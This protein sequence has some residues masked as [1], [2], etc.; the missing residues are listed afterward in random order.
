M[1]RL[2]SKRPRLRLDPEGYDQLRK[3]DL[4][5]SGATF[6]GEISS[7]REHPSTRNGWRFLGAGNFIPVWLSCSACGVAACVPA[8]IAGVS[9]PHRSKRKANRVL[10][11]TS[12]SAPRPWSPKG[13]SNQA[14]CENRTRNDPAIVTPLPAVSPRLSVLA[15]FRLRWHRLG[16]SLLEQPCL[17][18]SP[19]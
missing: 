15:R 7:H 17:S 8:I 13:K 18:W 16:V 2:R 1:N 11:T 10:N 6:G 5:P 3:L 4:R 14:L 9:F 19:P 12:P